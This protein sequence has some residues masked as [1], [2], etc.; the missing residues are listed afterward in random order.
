MTDNK[1]LAKFEDRTLTREEWTHEAHV[2]MA[3]LY[4]SRSDSYRDARS[5]VRTGIKKLNAAFLAR[6]NAP[7][8]ATRPP[9]VDANADPAAEPKPVGFHETITT[10]FLRLIADRAKDGESFAA[11]RKRNP[12]FF[13]RSLSALLAHY[14]P[15]VLFSDEAKVKFVQPDRE[16][17]PKPWR[18]PVAV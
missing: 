8:G 10:A 14:S 16:P 3:W 12:E 6:Q 18:V 5:K 9:E 4:V 17:L 15:E 1:F 13:D 7:C 11:F 2:R